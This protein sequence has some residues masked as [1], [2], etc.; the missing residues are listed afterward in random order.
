MD[1]GV[2][3][4]KAGRVAG[5]GVVDSA[6]LVERYYGGLEPQDLRGR[7]DDALL[8]AVEQHRALAAVRPPGEAL[9][10]VRPGDPPVVEVVTDDMP[11][12]VD[13][14]TAE[15]VRRGGA[16]QLVV[17]PQFRV[18]R[19]AL[20]RLLEIGAG[21]VESWIHLEVG[22]DPDLAAL[23]RDI[24]GV[25][26]D[27]RSAYED[28][29]AMRERLL[30]LAGELAPDAPAS[31]GPDGEAAE[32]ALLMR[33]LADGNLTLLGQVELVPAGDRLQVA[34][35]SALGLLRH[36][37]HLLE[38][39]L[40]P[41]RTLLMVTKSGSR[42]SV[43]RRAYLDVVS[44]AR[45]AADGTVVGVQRTLGLFASSAYSEAVRRTPVVRR[46]VAQAL[47]QSGYGPTSHDGRDLLAVLES[48]PRDELFQTGVEDLTRIATS[49]LRLR[50]RR[51]LRLFLRR[52]DD[53]RAVSALVYL[54]RDRYNTR[55][56]L[57]IAQ[58]L[59]T[60]FDAQS[61]DFTVRVTES[62]LARLHFVVRARPGAVLP[63]VDVP[64]L[65]ARLAAVARSWTDDLAEATQAAH[66]PAEAARL[67]R[68]YGEAFPEAYKEDFPASTGLVDL[69]RLAALPEG[70]GLTT[71]TYRPAAEGGAALRLK[72]YRA[73][74]LALSDALPVLQSLGV[75]VLDERPYGLRCGDGTRRWVYDFGLR[76]RPGAQPP[77]GDADPLLEQALAAAW[78][79]RLEAD[80]LNALVTHARLPWRS[81]LVL[82]AYATYLRQ[83]SPTYS[84][85]Y[86]QD[87][88][89]ANGEFA[90]LLV[91]LFEALLDPDRPAPE[92]AAELRDRADRLLDEVQSLDADRILR[93]LLDLVR[94]T[95]RT[96]YWQAKPHLSLKL[97][98]R[99]VP[100]LPQPRP[101]H[102]IWVYSPRFE[103][104]H[105]RFGAVARGGLRWS[106][107][108][109]DFRAEVF[110]LV[111]AQTVKNAVIV[112]TGA[113]GGFVGKQ[114]PDPALD[115]AAWLAEGLECY[116]GFIRGLLD[117][118][119]DLVDGQVEPPPQVLRR[120][121]D[122]TYLVV[123]ADKGTATFSDTAND[124]AAEYDF[125]LGDAF[126]SG[127][128]AGYDHKAMGI[129]A[130]GAWESVRRHFAELGV[131]VDRE[132][133]TA[134]GIGD[135]S[136]DV[137]GNGL[138]LSRSLRL[139]AAFDHRHVFVDPD[140]DPA[141]SYDERR[142]L[143]DLPRSSWADYDPA[144]LSAGGGVY[145][146][147][148]KSVPISPQV[149]ARLQLAEGVVALTPA[150]LVRAV[151]TAP[152]DL[153]WNGGIGTYVKA[154]GETHAQVGDKANDAVRI[155]GDQ[156]RARVV[157]E[158]GNLGLTQL[159]RVQYALAGGRLNTDAIDNSAGVDTSDHEVNF[160]IALQQAALGREERDAL[161]A[162]L[163]DEVAGRVLHDDRSQNLALS[164]SR[165]QAP[166]M[167]QVHARLLA[168]LEDRGVLERALEFLPSE[169]A[170]EQRAPAGLT[171][172]ELS[173]LLGYAKILLRADLLASTLPED[174][175]ALRA[176]HAYFPTSLQERLP[177]LDRHPLR[178]QIISTVIVNE[179]VDRGGITFVFRACEETGAA[180][181]E[182]VRAYAVAR[183][184]FDVA[185]LWAA[186]QGLAPAAQTL[187]LLKV[188][189]LLD[190]AVRWLLQPRRPAVDVDAEIAR[191]Q[192]ALAELTPRV[193]ELLV[194]VEADRLRADAQQLADAGVPT[195][196][197][198]RA[199]GLLD[200]FA[201]LDVVDL[202]GASARPPA[203]VARTYF[204]LSARF[205]GESLLAA[206]SRLPRPDRWQALARSALRDDVYAALAGL[207]ADVLRGAPGGAAAELAIDRW[208][209]ANADAVTRART[210]LVE[211]LAAQGEDG[212]AA[213]SVALR[214]IRA[215][216]PG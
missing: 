168:H 4:G 191:L 151:L 59:Q 158:G 10:R 112:P 201:L 47:Q 6:E 8:E 183:E 154:T 200:A 169:A 213:V 129:T 9:V 11:F 149:R 15:V 55:V 192:P 17:H 49:V 33:W 41:Q 13:S 35:G 207:T 44:V 72:L 135:M 111:R 96:N 131:D 113:K 5:P 24:A 206:I 48:F 209:L 30:A 105:L 36:R 60:G 126:A 91:S 45:R 181:A 210:T 199:A 12:L 103:G 144:L 124:V 120:D 43:H 108:R 2:S 161:L 40:G 67:L 99:Q 69:Q 7:D 88:L 160:K 100:Y 114:L 37:Q 66:G 116:R 62:V 52:D 68:D 182:V 147:T 1:D 81:V 98:P 92:R 196:L 46:K 58:V 145:P 198:L 107:R 214:S 79:G 167:R 187:V 211:V 153:L 203:D 130:R 177:Q 139:V 172:P 21:E 51:Q 188:K 163:T 176:L 70:G 212:L 86:I 208:E 165:A 75:D 140:P 164:L 142:R 28:G 82:R 94:A 215:L 118:T 195:A 3:T 119:D 162:D 205:Q 42:S 74:P 78:S 83:T 56:R 190:R 73:E 39:V 204:A 197:A 80:G 20:G 128:S 109:E 143:F 122:D 97:D 38:D 141:T 166:G 90:G 170:L 133:V 77:T 138:L 194:G 16:V 123:A 63:D 19:D 31:E 101:A 186:A 27:V 175:W 110:G 184:V 127:G 202:A 93:A 150:E 173:V 156:L 115:R 136:G 54:P 159:G 185:G 23:E 146:R 180:P 64:A 61:V 84:L 85:Q 25:L 125:W 189:R 179:V 76:Y 26:A 134:V 216:L 29:S 171:S 32:V 65:E 117:V 102:E 106:D 178:R 18:R 53:L 14:L 34:P 87:V 174:P 193:P 148:A 132:Q 71:A 22:G 104:V 155:D 137:F 157:G 152:V 50:E 121:G 89:V 57:A 95:V